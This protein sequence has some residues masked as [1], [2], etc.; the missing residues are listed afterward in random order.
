[1]PP[2]VN[3]NSPF[4][5]GPKMG[6]HIIHKCVLYLKIYSIPDLVFGFSCG[7][8]GLALCQLLFNCFMYDI[9]YIYL[10]LLHC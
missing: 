6:L 7:T 1:M 2:L 8:R 9:H 5:L 3:F 4:K 10:L